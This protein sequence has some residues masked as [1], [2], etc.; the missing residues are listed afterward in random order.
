MWSVTGKSYHRLFTESRMIF[1]QL[2]LY[3]SIRFTMDQIQN[4]QYDQ[5]L[6]FLVMEYISSSSIKLVARTLNIFLYSINWLLFSTFWQL[7]Y[8]LKSRL[9]VIL[10]LYLVYLISKYIVHYYVLQIIY[11][12]ISMRDVKTVK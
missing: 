2:F 4:N 6:L 9:P 11:T 12:I 8:L 1:Q 5:W 3:F 10:V 7:H